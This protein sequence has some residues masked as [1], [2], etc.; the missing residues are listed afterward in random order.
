MQMVGLFAKWNQY[1]GTN[2]ENVKFGIDIFPLVRETDKL[3]ISPKFAQ[4]RESLHW[5]KA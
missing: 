3:T 5:W 4:A 2:R 1:C